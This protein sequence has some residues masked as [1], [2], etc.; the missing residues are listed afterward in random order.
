[1]YKY[2]RLGYVFLGSDLLFYAAC[3]SSDKRLEAT[4]LRR[5]AMT[6]YKQR[7]KGSS[8]RVSQL[9]THWRREFTWQSH[10]KHRGKS[11]YL[12]IH[13]KTVLQ[14]SNKRMHLHLFLDIYHLKGTVKH[15]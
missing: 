7:K 3:I 15:L 14:K 9:P 1:M 8:L 5:L 11:F 2:I 4:S 6:V 13:Q 10:K 12:F